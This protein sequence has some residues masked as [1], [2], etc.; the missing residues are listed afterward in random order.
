MK[1]N[2][3]FRQA[4]FFVPIICLLVSF[5]SVYSEYARRDRLHQ[6]LIEADRAYE[7][8]EKTLHDMQQTLKQ[9]SLKKIKL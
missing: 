7:S 6:E 9:Q 5:N 8:S 3:P 1:S 2:S 4:F